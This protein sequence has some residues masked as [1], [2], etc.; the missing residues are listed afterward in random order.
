MRQMTHKGIIVDDQRLAFRR[1]LWLALPIA[2]AGVSAGLILRYFAIYATDELLIAPAMVG[3]ILAIKSV[4]D[5]VTDPLIG[6]LSDRRRAPRRLPFYWLGVPFAIAAFGLFFPPAG[7]DGLALVAWM[8]IFVVLWETGQ[9]LRQVSTVALGFEV[10]TDARQRTF[11]NVFLAVPG[12]IGSVAGIVAMQFVIDSGNARAALLPILIAATLFWLATMVVVGTR[13]K[14][15]PRPHRSEE[16]PPWHMLRE[17]VANPYHRQYIAM[18]LCGTLAFTSLAFAIP[19]VTKYV[20]GR[21]DMT[22]YVFLIFMGVNTLAVIGWWRLVARIG[23]RRVWLFGNLIW[24]VTLLSY[25]F[26]ANGGIEGFLVLAALAG[27][28]NSAG[29]CVGYAMLGDIADYDARVSGR[30]RQGIYATIYGLVDKIG[31]AAGAFVLGW[32]LQLSG[33]V[34][35]AEQGPQVLVAI[36]LAVSIIPAI[37]VGFSTLLLHRYRFYEEQ[38]VSDGS[39]GATALVARTA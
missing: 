21:A 37:G 30:Q 15:V 2:A 18:Q 11:L 23:V 33:F 22:M 4:F 24:L 1:F 31:A 25:P 19:Y 3:V 7:L 34:P 28:G 12:F 5:G 38:G 26:V 27:L 17:V 9:T 14:E 39:D 29:Y 13:L 32:A 20:F 36:T 35:N 10:A 16:R 8:V 6:W